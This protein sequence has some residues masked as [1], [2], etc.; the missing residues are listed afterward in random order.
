MDFIGGDRTH[1]SEF[2]ANLKNYNFGIA[3]QNRQI[4]KDIQGYKDQLKANVG[5]IN[6]NELLEQIKAGSGQVAELTG[7]QGLF[8]RIQKFKQ[9]GEKVGE[10]I[11]KARAVVGDIQSNVRQGVAGV[12][13]VAGQART[14]VQGAVQSAQEAGQGAIAQA[15]GAVQS[16]QEAGQGAIAQARGAVQSAQQ[17]GQ[18]AV[19]QARGILSGAVEEASN[20]GSSA[21]SSAVNTARQTAQQTAQNLVANN[22]TTAT[23]PVENRP[24]TNTTGVNEASAGTESESAVSNAIKTGQ[25]AVEE[26]ASKLSKFAGLGAK[27]VGGVGALAGMGMAIA[28][29]E[30]GGWAKK[31]LSDKIG[32]VAEIGG[33]G[34]DMAGLVLEATPLA[35]IGLAL[36]GIGTLFQIGSGIESEISSAVSSSDEKTEAGKEEQQQEQSEDKPQALLTGLSSAEAGGAGIARQQQ[37]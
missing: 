14:A 22:P 24:L 4:T 31:S 10:S 12:G 13:E 5:N 28:S 19:G 29:D 35:P 8:D 36:Q 33:A 30:N 26:G 7:A 32:N 18:E 34:M 15:R 3:E 25:E 21:V 23:P 37:N 20:V 2:E 11:T 6:T 9:A 17:A 16:A 1:D 27:T